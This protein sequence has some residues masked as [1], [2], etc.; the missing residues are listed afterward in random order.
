MKKVGII[1]LFHGS[2]NFGGVLQACAL[3]KALDQLGIPNEQI[4]CIYEEEPDEKRTLA[5]TLKKLMNPKVVWNRIRYELNGMKSEQ[6]KSG[7]REAFAGFN[8]RHV[9]SSQRV[10]TTSNVHECLGDYG[11]FITGSDQ[12]WNPDWYCRTYFLDFVPSDVTKISYAASLGKSSLTEIQQERFRKHLQDYKAVSV[13]E[14]DAVG[15]VAP[16]SP[17]PVECVLDPTLLLEKEQWYDVCAD[18]LVEGEYLF[19]YFL[20]KDGPEA[21][22]AEEYARRT[23]LKIAG[24]PNSA[25]DFSKTETIVYD[26]EIMD[27]SPAEFLSL[28]RHAKVVLTDS[29]HATVFS[30]LFEKEYFAF[31]RADHDGMNSRIL[32]VASLHDTLERFCDTPEKKTV[33]HMENAAPIDWNRPLPE[34]K[35]VR[36]DSLRFLKNNLSDC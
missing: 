31:P 2:L 30:N 14:S 34:L 21:A 20:G 22:L 8:Q 32:R 7:R 1:T 4:R 35:Q 17:V 9:H 27:A 12:V 28:I 33:A 3:C 16:L 25:R 11:A 6:Q 23:G 18:R 26:H 5:G 15:I 10:Y 29:F 13:R 19:Y 36:D 24:I